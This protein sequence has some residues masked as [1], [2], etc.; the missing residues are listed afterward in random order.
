MAYSMRMLLQ[1]GRQVAASQLRLSTSSGSTS[2][3]AASCVTLPST[4]AFGSHLRGGVVAM[5]HGSHTS[6]NNPDTLLH[7]K[8]RNLEG[9]CPA[10]SM[11][12]TVHKPLTAT[13]AWAAAG[14]TPEV[15]PGAP[16]WNPQ[17]AS[18][19]EAAVS[20]TGHAGVVCATRVAVWAGVS[21]SGVCGRNPAPAAAAHTR[22]KHLD[23]AHPRN[24]FLTCW[25][26]RYGVVSPLQPGSCAC[27]AH[28]HACRGPAAVVLR[29]CWCHQG[30]CAGTQPLET[31]NGPP[32]H[33]PWVVPATI[34]AALPAQSWSQQAL[35]CQHLP[36]K[37]WTY[38]VVAADESGVAHQ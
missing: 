35:H 36:A 1:T 17:L 8:T 24:P 28:R 34:S 33:T 18:D 4:R 32:A 31:R 22:C 21:A 2:A 16:G 37:Y 19:S 5:G 26:V 20:G 7:E 12:R 27:G 23:P 10:D 15:V 13:H 6:D 9:G 30:A 3:A 25:Q 38:S 29:G 14:K 11:C